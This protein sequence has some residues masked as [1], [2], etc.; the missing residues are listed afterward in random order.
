MRRIGTITLGALAFAALGIAGPASA[1]D[2]TLRIG[3]GDIATV[4]TLG[5]L[6]AL[7][8]VEER[9]VTVDLTAFKSEDIAAQAVVNGQ[10]DVGVGTPYALIQKL[11]APV[12]VFF[13]LSTLKFYPV[14]SNEYPD[15]QALDGKQFVYHAR[16]C[17]DYT[18]R[19]CTR[20]FATKA[21]A[22]AAGFRAHT[23]CVR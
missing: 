15:W 1:Q 16:G 12:R 18:C 7:E 3:L 19:S 10:V 17:N 23:K 5:L 22:D 20:T 21:A 13:Q 9:G 11:D 14:V 4:E 8:R 6:I 2:Q